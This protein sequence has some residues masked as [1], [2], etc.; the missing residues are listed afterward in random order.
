MGAFMAR[1]RLLIAG[2][3]AGLS[4]LSGRAM[5]DGMLPPG[6]IVGY[7]RPWSVEVGAR[8][9]YSTG[10]NKYDYFDTTG[11]VLVSRLTYDDTHANSGEGFFRVDHNNGL[12]LKG[13]FG[14]GSNS[15]GTLFDEDFPP[16]VAPYSRT[17]SGL[18]G[19][20]RYLT[21]DLG[22][23]FYD[24]SRVYRGGLKDAPVV[25]HGFRLGGFVGYN[26]WNGKQDAFGCTQL[27][28]NPGICTP[29][30]VLPGDRVIT[31]KDTWNSLRLGLIADAMLTNRLKLTGE[32]AYLRADQKA[33]DI[34]YFTF[35]RDPASGDGWGYQLEAILAYQL[36]DIFN[37]GV[38]G[39]WWHMETDAT[40]SFIQGL[41]Y[42]TD[43]YGV[44]VQGSLKFN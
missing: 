36:T 44:F 12:F 35:G 13:F 17:S 31:E 10:K 1:A 26:Y 39:R 6:V 16:V 21:V 28:T 32:A 34:H 40:D 19:N 23:T 43:R 4:L 24:S 27:A 41:K 8:Y 30:A 42:D 14:A 38:G 37:V 22:Y 11:T 9:W 29:G 7:E 2:L 18:D 25:R 15:N 3:S 5:A 20:L 33:L